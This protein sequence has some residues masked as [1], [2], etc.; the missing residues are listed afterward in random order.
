MLFQTRLLKLFAVVGVGVGGYFPGLSIFQLW[1]CWPGHCLPPA[2]H[3]L[4]FNGLIGFHFLG[5]PST[6]PN[7]QLPRQIWLA[8]MVS[9]GLEFSRPPF[10]IWFAKF[11]CWILPL[12]KFF[13]ISWAR[14]WYFC[15]LVL[16]DWTFGDNCIIMLTACKESSV[17]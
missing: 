17:R 5:Y 10:P 12:C 7:F 2:Y 9:R 11:P 8:T 3:A 13:H 6:S 16:C 15:S 1:H 14:P 4:Y